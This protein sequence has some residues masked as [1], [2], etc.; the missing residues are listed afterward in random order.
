MLVGSMPAATVHAQNISRENP[1][2]SC[3]RVV[4]RMLVFINI[5]YP[6]YTGRLP[7]LAPAAALI[8]QHPAVAAGLYSAVRPSPHLLKHLFSQPHLE[9]RVL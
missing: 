1:T 6:F 7:V 5:S 9:L 8:K 2:L 3:A 4:R